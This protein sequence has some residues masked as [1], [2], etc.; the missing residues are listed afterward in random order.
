AEVPNPGGLLLPGMY[1]RVRIEQAQISQAL[2]VPQQAVMRGPQGDSVMVVG[3]DDK[4]APRPV[5]ISAA[6]G[7]Q[8]VVREGLKAGERVMVDGFQKLHGPGP[9]TPVP[10]QPGAASAPASAASGR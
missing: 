1:V 7:G 2:V 6:Q 3:A 9:V 10:W 8:W 4:A 5:K